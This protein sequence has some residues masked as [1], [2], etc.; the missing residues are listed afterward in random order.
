MGI[1]K[2]MQIID[3]EDFETVPVF[4]SELLDTA[5][6]NPERVTDR[7]EGLILDEI[8][9]DIAKSKKCNPNEEGEC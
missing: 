7:I 2:N 6:D 5:L 4:E 3:S 1:I 8:Y 9:E